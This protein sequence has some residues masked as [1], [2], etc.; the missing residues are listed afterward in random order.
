M[1]S[2]T[3]GAGGIRWGEAMC[4]EDLKG[5]PQ[6]SQ[7]PLPVGSRALPVQNGEAPPAPFHPRSLAPDV[8]RQTPTQGQGTGLY[9]WQNLR[10]FCHFRHLKTGETNQSLSNWGGAFTMTALPCKES[11]TS[12]CWQCTMIPPPLTPMGSWPCSMLFTPCPLPV[13]LCPF[14]TCRGH[15]SALSCPH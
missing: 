11:V 2:P 8:T 6:G 15:P 4:G 12:L 9:F 5:S 3:P 10:R 14:S 1:L 7:S 13:P